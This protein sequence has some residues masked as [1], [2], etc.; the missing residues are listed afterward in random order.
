MPRD[1]RHVGR[2]HKWD[3][4]SPPTLPRNALQTIV[5]GDQCGGASFATNAHVH[6]LHSGNIN[7]A[8]CFNQ[9]P[10]SN[11]SINVNYGNVR[12]TKKIVII[13]HQ[14]P[15]QPQGSEGGPG[16]D[17]AD[18]SDDYDSNSGDS[19]IRPDRNRNGRNDHGTE[20]VAVCGHA[21]DPDDGPDS[22]GGILV[23][24]PVTVTGTTQP[25]QEHMQRMNAQFFD[26]CSDQE[27]E[28]GETETEEEDDSYRPHMPWRFPPRYG[29]QIEI[30]EPET[31]GAHDEL[32]ETEE[33]EE[34]SSSET[35]SGRNKCR[36]KMNKKEQKK[37]KKKRA[38]STKNKKKMTKKKKP[39]NDFDFDFFGPRDRRDGDGDDGGGAA[40]PVVL[41]C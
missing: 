7:L 11:V 10:G 34:E 18:E 17:G 14:D 30:E 9:S 41:Q 15:A 25:S 4:R 39:H 31:E 1:K 27:D 28:Q 23:P 32:L 19:S 37:H 35:D 13:H 26:L 33:E 22:C 12:I 6:G 38:T 3:P 5:Q 29:E 16:S 40:A 20:S 8:N 36:T 21:P 2:S 24:V